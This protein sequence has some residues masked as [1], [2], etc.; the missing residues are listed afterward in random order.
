VELTEWGLVLGSA[1]DCKSLTLTGVM[2]LKS[3]TLKPRP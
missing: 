2:S 3:V 1:V